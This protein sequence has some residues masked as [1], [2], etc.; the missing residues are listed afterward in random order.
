MDLSRSS[1]ALRKAGAGAKGKARAY[2]RRD[3]S[4]FQR[5]IG[6]VEGKCPF[7][8]LHYDISHDADPSVGAL[9]T[10]SA[11]T[12]F[13]LGVHVRVMSTSGSAKTDQFHLRATWFAADSALLLALMIRRSFSQVLI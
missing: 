13:I 8:R 6:N 5:F 10:G 1:R 12:D 2:L 4:S 11:I 7:L 9:P 3:C